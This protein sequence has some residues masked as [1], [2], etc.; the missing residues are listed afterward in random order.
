M[1]DSRTNIDEQKTI[2]LMESVAPDAAKE[3]IDIV[4]KL[5][6]AKALSRTL[7]FQCPHCEASI[8]LTATPPRAKLIF[9]TPTKVV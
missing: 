5:V 1:N 7:T 8:N 4:E 3:L 6:F 2:R 9:E